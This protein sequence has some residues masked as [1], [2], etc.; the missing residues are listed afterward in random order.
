[1]IS[2]LDYSHTGARSKMG[3]WNA[4]GNRKNTVLMPVIY[5][6]NRAVHYTAR[7]KPIKT[8]LTITTTTLKKA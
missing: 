7:K 3:I 1:M 8:N 2:A 6:K 4:K 5:N